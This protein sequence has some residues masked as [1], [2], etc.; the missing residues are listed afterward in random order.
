M[1]DKS[2]FEKIYDVVK[3]IPRGKVATYGQVALLAG[4][5]RWAR[6][7]GYALHVNPDPDTIPCYR[8]VNREGRVSPAFAF[9][10]EN[11]QI[12]MLEGDGIK[13]TDGKVDLSVCQWL[14]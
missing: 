14:P 2:V 1:M 3:Q 13:V 8:V 10:G 12:L 9:G 11:M 7:V 4:N 5:P 6:V